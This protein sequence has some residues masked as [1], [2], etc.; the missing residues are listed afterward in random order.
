MLVVRC[1]TYSTLLPRL[2]KA[3]IIE[4]RSIPEILEKYS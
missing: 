4:F 2:D 3:K 1:R